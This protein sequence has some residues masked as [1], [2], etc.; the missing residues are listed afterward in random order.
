MRK[1]RRAILGADII[2]LPIELRRVMNMKED[3]QNVVIADHGRIEFHA[4]RLGMAGVAVADLAIGRRGHMPAGVAVFDRE[5][6]VQIIED[7][8]DAP[9]A[10]ARSEER[11]VGKEC[12]SP[13][14]SRWLPYH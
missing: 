7:R 6:A 14:R 13:C 1:Y 3:I 9:E 4:H 12:V 5:H 2:A 10:A 11:R 8:L